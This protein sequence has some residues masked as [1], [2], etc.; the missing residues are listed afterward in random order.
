MGPFRRRRSRRC[1]CGERQRLQ[2]EDLYAWQLLSPLIQGHPYLPFTGAAMRPICLAHVFNDVVVNRRR[3]VLE[4]GVGVSTLLLGR[5]IRQCGLPAS[6]LAVEHDAEW[7]EQIRR[8]VAAESL[9]RFVEV[10][11][12][13]LVAGGPRGRWYDE[14]VISQACGTEAFDL[15]VVDGP[16]AWQ[17][18]DEEARYPALGF[19]LPLLAERCAVYLDD[20]NREGERAALERWQRESDLEFEVVSETLA[21]ARRG[22]AF[23]TDPFAYYV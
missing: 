22:A 21:R 6:V 5:L 10:L 15:V 1:G 19:I 23:D 4:F 2:L 9:E 18:G 12:A 13:P 20:A 16:P 3:R 7:A 17:S 14:P 11:S 8:Q